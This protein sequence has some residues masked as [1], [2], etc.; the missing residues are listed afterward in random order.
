MPPRFALL[1]LG[2]IACAAYVFRCAERVR[3]DWPS[4]SAADSA[5]NRDHIREARSA[6]GTPPLADFASV[7]ALAPTFSHPDRH[8]RGGDGRQAA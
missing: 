2:L 6:S 8:H 1:G 7:G 5:R 4:S 3:R